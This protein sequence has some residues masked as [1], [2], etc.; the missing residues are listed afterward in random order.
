MVTATIALG[1][2]AA[3]I[4]RGLDALGHAQTAVAVVMIMLA[5]TT[6][7]LMPTLA[8]LGKAL[9]GSK[10]SRERDALTDDLDEDRERTTHSSSRPSRTWRLLGGWS[11]SRS[12]RS[13]RR[14]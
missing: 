14:S 12:R 1:I 6:G 3:L 8:F 13:C 11:A 9:D 2:T 7:L 5:V 10:V 4:E